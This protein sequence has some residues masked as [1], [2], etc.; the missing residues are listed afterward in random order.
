MDIIGI[1]AKHMNCHGRGEGEFGICSKYVDYSTKKASLKQHDP[2]VQVSQY[3]EHN[4]MNFG[5]N[6]MFSLE[7]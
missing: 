4:S 6:V 5:K 3:F 1:S 7:S 2:P